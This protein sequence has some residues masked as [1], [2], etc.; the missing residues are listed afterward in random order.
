MTKK[1][2]GLPDLPRGYR[3]RIRRARTD[4][5]Y[6]IHNGYFLEIVRGRVFKRVLYWGAVVSE[7]TRTR[8]TESEINRRDSAVSEARLITDES[9]RYAADLLLREF[10]AGQAD[11]AAHKKYVGLYPPNSL[12]SK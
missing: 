11:A 5:G 10:T 7:Q 6:S 9:I 12:D 8:Y 2:T 4:D 1:L 3:W